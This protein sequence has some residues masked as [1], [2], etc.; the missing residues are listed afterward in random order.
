MLDVAG[1][2]QRAAVDAVL[3]LLCPTTSSKGTGFLLANGLVV[4]TEHVVQGARARDIVGVDRRG[5]HVPFKAVFIDGDRDLAVLR[6]AKRMEGGLTLSPEDDPAAGRVVTTWGFPL[7]HFGTAP[8]LSVGYV[9]GSS[10]P[11]AGPRHVRQLVV[12]GAFNAGNSGG[13]LFLAGDDRVLGVVVSKHLPLT[14]FVASAIDALAA[15]PRGRPISR[16]TARA[17]AAS[18]SSRSSSPRCFTTCTASPR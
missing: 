18:S 15:N 4:T 12:N 14:P 16:R 6:P 10:A 11:R 7:G 1:P 9:A 13:P 17:S 5:N 2:S 8:L 3:M